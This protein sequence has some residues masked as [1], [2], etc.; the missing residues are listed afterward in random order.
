MLCLSMSQMV[1][2]IKRY[3]YDLSNLENVTYNHQRNNF[4]KYFYLNH[5]GIT[6]GSRGFYLCY[7]GF[8]CNELIS[9][10]GCPRTETSCRK[11][12]KNHGFI[13]NGERVFSITPFIKCVFLNT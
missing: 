10:G 12:G 7:K 1:W 8:I 13:S 3:N 9:F 5:A 11:I 6:Q 4:S 2:I